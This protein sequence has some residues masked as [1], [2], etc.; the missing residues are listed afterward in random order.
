[1]NN[2]PY[3]VDEFN[4]D[5]FYYKNFGTT[6]RAWYWRW[7]MQSKWFIQ[8]LKFK[9]PGHNKEVRNFL[10]LDIQNLKYGAKQF[11][12]FNAGLR[13]VGKDGN[14]YRRQFKVWIGYRCIELT[15]VPNSRPK[16]AKG[17]KGPRTYK[18]GVRIGSQYRWLGIGQSGIWKIKLTAIY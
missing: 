13:Y 10:H 6:H 9:L 8:N 2:K 7:F 11:S 12:Y 15:E 18:V 14:M 1:M 3:V 4:I 17:S 16:L 5:E